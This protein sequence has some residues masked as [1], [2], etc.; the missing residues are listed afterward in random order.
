MMRTGNSLTEPSPA[1]VPA[2]RSLAAVT[3]PAAPLALAAPAAAEGAPV[4]DLGALPCSAVDAGGFVAAPASGGEG[5]PQVAMVRLPDGNRLAL[6]TGG[7]RACSLTALSGTHSHANGETFDAQALQDDPAGT[8]LTSP[9]GP[10]H[11]AAARDGDGVHLAVVAP[12]EGL[13]EPLAR[14]L[15]A[16]R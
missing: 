9:P 7:P 4:V 3:L 12:A 5:S 11:S 2:G 13:S 6:H 16:V 8:L 14:P 10:T 1:A 15:D